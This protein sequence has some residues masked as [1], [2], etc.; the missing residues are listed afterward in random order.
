MKVPFSLPSSERVEEAENVTSM[1]NAPVPTM[2]TFEGLCRGT[3]IGKSKCEE[4]VR[5]DCAVKNEGHCEGRG[6]CIH[7]EN[8][9]CCYRLECPAE[10]VRPDTCHGKDGGGYGSCEDDFGDDCV[11]KKLDRSCVHIQTKH[12]LP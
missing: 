8:K 1:K 2:V 9:D 5:S 3:G 7:N 12:Q 10:S 4:K 11:Q 6:T